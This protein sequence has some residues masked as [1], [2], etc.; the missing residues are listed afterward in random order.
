MATGALHPEKELTGIP[1]TGLVFGNWLFS[2][3][4]LVIASVTTTSTRPAD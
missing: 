2:V 4:N 1:G 3:F